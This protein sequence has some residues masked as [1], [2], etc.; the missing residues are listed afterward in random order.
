MHRLFYY[1][2]N[3]FEKFRNLVSKLTFSI[4]CIN[5]E[6]A[7]SIYNGGEQMSG[8]D[9]LISQ[10]AAGN[11]QAFEE[12]YRKTNK[13]VYFTCLSF[14]KNKQD[15]ADVTQ[16]VYITVLQSL[17]DLKDPT[18]FEG[19]ISRIAVNK[20]KDF[21]KK[22]RPV[23]V[24]DET[25]TLMIDSSDNEVLLP[26]DY[27]NDEEKRRIIMEII[28]DSLSDILYQTVVLFYFHDMTAADIAELMDCP[29]GTVTS[30]LCIARAKI[31]KAVEDYEEKNNDRL[32]SVVPM[33]LLGAILKA[34]A[35]ALK[36]VDRWANILSATSD[37]MNT[38]DAAVSGNAAANALNAGGK[39]MLSTLKGKIL[40]GIIAAMVAAA[41]ITAAIMISNNAKDK[42]DDDDEE[43]SKPKSEI[44]LDEDIFTDDDEIVTTT[45]KITTTT[46]PTTTEGGEIPPEVEAP[47]AIPYKMAQ[48]NKKTYQDSD[49]DITELWIA[50]ELTDAEWIAIYGKDAFEITYTKTGQPISELDDINNFMNDELFIETSFA[51]SGSICQYDHIRGEETPEEYENLV[52]SE[53]RLIVTMCIY[54]NKDIDFE[55]FSI[56]FSRLHYPSDTQVTTTLEY[57]ADISQITTSPEVIHGG[58]LFE[59]DGNYYVVNLEGLNRTNF[60]YDDNLDNEEEPA[61]VYRYFEVK[62]AGNNSVQALADSLNGNVQ[63]VYGSESG[64]YLDD[65]MESPDYL[66]PIDLG[67]GY[68]IFVEVI[69]EED[70]RI[71]IGFEAKDGKTFEEDSEIYNTIATSLPLY[72]SDEGKEILFALNFVN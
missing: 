44:T 15:A 58:N 41:G 56:D 16:E 38:A 39:T 4:V 23:P 50:V 55:D 46:P 26:D 45:N 57:N 70:G 17:S 2:K 3:F 24:D 53:D 27:V 32:H 21:L 37:I 64:F 72:T 52:F 10:A 36:P 8:Y 9:R 11:Q 1:G 48:I 14:L 61:R 31:K 63:L 18:V 71:A 13:K 19:W 43:S 66:K 6:V 62:C 54:S 33:S 68:E 22:K 67:E 40:A 49:Y 7:E 59:I 34:E 69:D 42:A 35:A 20:C 51:S 30:R 12:I 28:R 65:E 5:E 60:D 47:E 25:L 29:V